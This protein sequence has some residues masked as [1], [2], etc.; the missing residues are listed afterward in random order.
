MR[1]KWEKKFPSKDNLF[2]AENLHLAKFL[3]SLP[4]TLLAYLKL[5]IKFI[6]QVFSKR[7]V[8]I[9]PLVFILIF[10][11]IFSGWP[12][13]YNFPMKVE[14]AEAATTTKTWSFVAD[15]ESWSATNPAPTTTTPQW[16]SADGSPA[17]GSLEMR[18]TGKNKENLGRIWEVAGTWEAIFSIPAGSTITEVGSGSGNSYNYRV[19]EYNVGA[20]GNSGPFAFYDNTPTLQGTF[21]TATAFSGLVAW[22]TKTGTAISVPA[23]LQASNSTVRFRITNDLATGN[24]NGAAV[25]LRQD[26]VVL[27]ITYTPPAVDTPT[28]TDTTG[29]YNN[30]L[31][32]TITVAS[33]ASA[34]ICYT[35]DGSTPAA[36]TP[37]T[38]STGTTY[39]GAVS[40]TATGTTLKAIGTKAGYTNSAMQSATYTLQVADPA[41]GTNGGSFNNDT[42]STQTS[43][44]TGAVFCQTVDGTTNPEAST[45]GTCSVGTTGADATVIATGKTIKAL[46]TKAN[47]VNSA[48]QTSNA[49]TLTVGAITSSPGPDTYT[50]TQSVTLNIATTTG[51]VAHYTTNGDAVTCSS[52][53]YSGAFDVSVTTTVKAIGCKTNYVSDTPIS[54]LYT[55]G[56][57]TAIEVRAQNY[58]TSVSTV[59]FPQGAPETTISAPYNNI[60]SSGNSQTF[61]GAGTAK[62]V[63]TLYNGGGSTLTIWYNITTF[64]LGIVSSEYYLVNAKGAACADANCIT[65]SVTFDA[66]TPTGTTIVAGAGN[67]KDLYLKTTLSAV[68]GKSGNSTLTIL[69]EGL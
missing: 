30:D 69:G 6:N 49:F 66:D 19:S 35:T 44:T 21:S 41:F 51:A 11:W 56:L 9:R 42:T 46:G 18:I 28:F 47:Y 61:G 39:T 14:K 45:P 15:T 50:S 33:P 65:E 4:Q 38:C 29:T 1:S 54:D 7:A 32:E 2:Y 12:Q 10:S 40:I 31:S 27:T 25:T 34:T 37:G 24:N 55:I 62:P 68:A 8:I 17:N 58:T 48:V 57:S 5:P 63:V 64:T 67:E 60:D 43:T 26:Q 3:R 52:T 36:S 23:G 59:T 20:A 22:A 16:Q 53:T 13:I